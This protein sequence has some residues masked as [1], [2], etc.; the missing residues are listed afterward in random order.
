M[1][2]LNVAQVLDYQSLQL[3]N[4]RTLSVN[5]KSIYIF[6]HIIYLFNRE[7]WYSGSLDN[8]LESG[9]A[10]YFIRLGS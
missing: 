3:Q 8:C 7:V 9:V 4:N 6:L 10:I 2:L 1:A 5:R